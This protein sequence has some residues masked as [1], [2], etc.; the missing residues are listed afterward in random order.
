MP[1]IIT[2]GPD[3]NLWFTESGPGGVGEITP[4]GV[5][6]EYATPSGSY[7]NFIT[8]GPDGNLWFTEG[9]YGNGKIG[10]IT[11]AGVVTEYATPSGSPPPIPSS[12][13]RPISSTFKRLP[14]PG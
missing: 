14:L 10:K 8:T 5:I 11:P 4:A 6:I 12:T 9:S 7:T 3:N 1:G 13:A 2:A